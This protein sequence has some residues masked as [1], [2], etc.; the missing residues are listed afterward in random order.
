MQIFYLKKLNYAEVKKQYQVKISNG[1]AALENLDGDV[2][3]SRS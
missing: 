3:F 1:F 2:N